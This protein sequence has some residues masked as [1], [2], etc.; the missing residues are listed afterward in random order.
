MTKDSVFS[1]QCGVAESPEGPDTYLS[2]RAGR[3][4]V[5]AFWHPI[6]DPQ[7]PLSL[8]ELARGFESAGEVFG[9]HRDP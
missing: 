8:V 7:W 1:V 3:C 9:E 4:K 6:W 5:W 2:L